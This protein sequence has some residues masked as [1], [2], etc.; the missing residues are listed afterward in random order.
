MILMTWMFALKIQSMIDEKKNPY[1]CGTKNIVIRANDAYP[2]SKDFSD[3][4]KNKSN[5]I[6]RQQFLKAQFIA[7]AKTSDCGVI[8][9]IQDECCSLVT[10]QRKNHLECHHME[11]DT[12]IV[13]TYAKLREKGE[14]KTVITDAEDTDAL[15][16]TAHVALE[17]ADVLDKS[18]SVSILLEIHFHQ[19]SINSL[20]YN[21]IFPQRQYILLFSFLGLKKKKAVFNCK[22][23]YSA[24]MAKV[25]ISLHANTGVDLVS[26]FFGQG[27]ISFWH[28]VEKSLQEA[29]S[30]L[31]GE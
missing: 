4:F 24:E 14:L 31:N 20:F 19:A 18:M 1:I 17:I 16:L 30:L 29:I 12:I 21:S 15:V 28:K 7:E 8:Y 2:S 9:S 6:C 5:K 25:I 26:D 27:K 3:F 13:Y 22:E 23:L 10:G 11:A